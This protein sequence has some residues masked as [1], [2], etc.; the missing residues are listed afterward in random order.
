MKIVWLTK[1][2]QLKIFLTYGRK[3]DAKILY[4]RIVA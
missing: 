2:P 1:A 4:V 3:F